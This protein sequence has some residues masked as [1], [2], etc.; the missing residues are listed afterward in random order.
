MDPRSSVRLTAPVNTGNDMYK[1]MRVSVKAIFGSK[2]ETLAFHSS[3]CRL[4]SILETSTAP[5]SFSLM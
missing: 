1:V 2:Y 4:M 5:A 3:R